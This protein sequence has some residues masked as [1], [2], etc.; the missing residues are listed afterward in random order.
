MQRLALF[1]S[2]IAA[3]TAAEA[4]VRQQPPNKLSPEASTSVTLGGKN[5]TIEY[6]APSARGRKVEGGLIP[7][8]KV[9]RTGADSA[10]TLITEADL[11]IGDLRVA[12]GTYTIYTFA[13]DGDW[14]LAISKQTGQWGTEY[15]EPQDLGRTSLSLK[16]LGAPVEKFAMAL[17][18]AG[19]NAATLT[20]RWGMTEA[21]VAVKLA[22]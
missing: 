16:K 7:Y 22:E 9:W 2:L 1:L 8:G 12:K 13:T 5:V 4:G 17:T 20:L 10:T 21:S 19:S 18:A 14:K 15:N 6:S 3:V 11:T